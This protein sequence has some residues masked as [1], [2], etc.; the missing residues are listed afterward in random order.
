MA[1][2]GA[3]GH[4]LPHRVC[5]LVVGGLWRSPGIVSFSH[6]RYDERMLFGNLLYMFSL[7]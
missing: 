3:P 4:A 7:K 6:Q 5:V 2:R 1:S